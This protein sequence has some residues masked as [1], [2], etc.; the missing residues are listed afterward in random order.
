MLLRP[1]GRMI[2]D[3]PGTAQQVHGP[4][5][6]GT[7][8]FRGDVLVLGAEAARFLPHVHGNLLHT[9]VEDP[10]QP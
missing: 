5:L 7:A 6:H 4:T 2:A 3:Q 8:F 9:A 1:L 10:Y